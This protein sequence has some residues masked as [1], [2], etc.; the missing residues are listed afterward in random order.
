MSTAN[1]AF[2][3][4]TGQL[5]RSTQAS[6]QL[7]RYMIVKTRFQT[8]RLN[9]YAGQGVQIDYIDAVTDTDDPALMSLFAEG[10]VDMICATCDY[11][12]CE[13]VHPIEN[14][15]E[16]WKAYRHHY[17]CANY[18]LCPD[19]PNFEPRLAKMTK[20]ELDFELSLRDLEESDDKQG[21][22]LFS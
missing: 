10:L 15:G 6:E 13:A 2:E 9:Q 8:Q 21:K 22:G 7:G 1:S 19:H 16:P 5:R 11:M 14:P 12:I 18:H 20:D 3:A 4:L 17:V